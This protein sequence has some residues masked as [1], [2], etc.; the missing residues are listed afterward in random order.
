ML[1]LGGLHVPTRARVAM[2]FD[3]SSPAGGDRTSR[4]S[5]T[6]AGDWTSR[7]GVVVPTAKVPGSGGGGGGGVG[8]GGESS[9][10]ARRLAEFDARSWGKAAAVVAG[11]SADGMRPEPVVG[12]GKG[13]GEAA[14]R[15][16]LARLD[17]PSWGAVAAAVREVAATVV[18]GPLPEEE[19]PSA[20]TRATR[21]SAEA[22][23]KAWLA[24]LDASAWAKAATALSE[25]A[26]SSA[27]ISALT[28]KCQSGDARS[29]EQLSLEEAA[30]RADTSLL[31]PAC[32][33]P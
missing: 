24:R 13:E 25:V 4:P 15:A 10:A 22:A 33:A 29:C 19:R 28:D 11:A 27:A 31:S 9:D 2:G 18:A 12:E 3:A 7:Q 6:P 8:G 16:W 17:A 21:R 14:K 5:A 30:R 23:R 32:T 20:G 26:G 1:V